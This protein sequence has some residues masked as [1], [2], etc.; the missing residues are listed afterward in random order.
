MSVAS[1]LHGCTIVRSLTTRCHCI[2]ALAAIARGYGSGQSLLTPGPWRR[3]SPTR[4]LNEHDGTQVR[5]PQ[6]TVR[7]A[8]LE[9]P[10]PRPGRGEGGEGSLVEHRIT[11]LDERARSLTECRAPRRLAEDLVLH[12][13]HRTEVVVDRVGI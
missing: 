10:S 8:V 6:G 13:Q 1:G 9:L 2:T 4:L 5:T 7:P 12:L 3:V 11:L